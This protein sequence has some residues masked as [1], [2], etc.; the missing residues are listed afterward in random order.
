MLIL[1]SGSLMIVALVVFATRGH[2]R[3]EWRGTETR[4]FEREWDL[5]I[6]RGRLY[7]AV[8]SYK[9]AYYEVRPGSVLT[10]LRRL[11]PFFFRSHLER[12]FQF[13]T[14]DPKLAGFL[15]S[16]EDIV[17]SLREMRSY[18]DFHLISTGQELHGSFKLKKTKLSPEL[19]SA[20]NE[21]DIQTL[22][23]GLEK[24]LEVQFDLPLNEMSVAEI[25]GWRRSSTLPFAMLVAGLIVS[26]LQFGL[27]PAGNEFTPGMLKM[28]FGLSIFATGLG[29][30]WG[31]FRSPPHDFSRM[32]LS[33]LL[34]FS[35]SVFLW[36][37]GVFVS[38]QY[39][40]GSEMMTEVNRPHVMDSS[41]SAD[42]AE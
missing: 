34:V 12:E 20:L 38:F 35:W 33:Y 26:L 23:T 19:E 8:P 6:H 40:S 2:L 15:S 31:A 18:G 27:L 36:M 9:T 5:R 1:L 11:M 16:R 29:L 10:R 39:L 30:L 4:L 7:F 42:Q 14:E 13:Q 3:R 24:L 25:Q 28:G 32:A 21:A 22:L 37:H 17:S 41:A